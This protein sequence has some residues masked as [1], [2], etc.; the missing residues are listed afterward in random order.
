MKERYYGKAA[1]ALLTAYCT[2]E[3]SLELLLDES[4]VSPQ[5]GNSANINAN[6]SSRIAENEEI[7]IIASQ[8]QAIVSD[9]RAPRYVIPDTV[10]HDPP[11]TFDSFNPNEYETMFGFT[12]VDVITMFNSFGIPHQ[13]QLNEGSHTF[14]V[15]GEHAF[16]YFLFRYHSPSQRQTLDTYRWHYDYSVL[17]KMFNTIVAFIDTNHKYL[18]TNYLGH[19]VPKFPLFNTF[20][21]PGPHR[22]FLHM[23]VD[24]SSGIAD[25]PTFVTNMKVDFGKALYCSS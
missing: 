12:K 20:L 18:L 15:S 23:I 19:I 8:L 5:S 11:I 3:E 16:L 25:L 2:E 10:Q 21:L 13:I 17:S 14:A 1:N 24:L 22:P 6:L 7:L 4:K 9:I